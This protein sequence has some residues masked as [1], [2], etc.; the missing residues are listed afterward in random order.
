MGSGQHVQVLADAFQDG[1]HQR[2]VDAIGFLEQVEH[3]MPGVDVQVR[4]HHAHLEREVHED[5]SQA[6]DVGQ[7]EGEVDCD[8][9]GAAAA[10]G[11]RD[12]DD[13]RGLR[14][15][16]VL[17]GDLLERLGEVLRQ[18]REMDDLRGPAS[19]RAHDQ[20]VVLGVR[21]SPIDQRQDRPAREGRLELA[22]R[23]EVV[24]AADLEDQQS[25]PRGCPGVDI[26]RLAR[27]GE[28]GLDGHLIAEQLASD[29]G[30]LFVSTAAQDRIH[31]VHVEI[32]SD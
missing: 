27:R 14:G 4:G 13:L 1:A 22:E 5:A 8:R 18:G 29:V 12:G 30:Q 3:R 20:A 26:R 32:S 24:R 17:D 15:V 16:D 2:R 6:P 9:R 7:L 31:R 19:H 25:G 10:G 21:L 11:A 23:V 28:L